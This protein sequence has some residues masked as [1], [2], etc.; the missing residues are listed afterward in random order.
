[1]KFRFGIIVFSVVALA[2][3]IVQVNSETV[4]ADSIVRREADPGVKP[5]QRKMNKKMGKRNADPRPPPKQMER[6]R[7]MRK[8]RDVDQA[9][10]QMNFEEASAETMVRREADPGMLSA[11]LS[12]IPG[13][14]K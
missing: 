5:I 4:E 1:M 10:D 14:G 3:A 6:L 11:L 12:L 8:G 9:I 2:F 13:I 7:E